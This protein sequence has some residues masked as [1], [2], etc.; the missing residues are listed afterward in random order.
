MLTPHPA[1]LGVEF[2]HMAN[3]ALII[4]DIDGTLLETDRVT[5]PA[6]QRTY[7]A[8]GLPVPDAAAICATFGRPVEEYLDWLASLCPP[9]Q[10]TE[11]TMAGT[12][13]VGKNC[14]FRR[15]SANKP[16]RI[17]MTMNRFA[18]VG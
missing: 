5:V 12:S 2:E 16:I 6:V 4:F 11:T 7:A 10:A 15:V 17:R 14:R 1:R 9:G 8:Y 18:A 3:H 13:K